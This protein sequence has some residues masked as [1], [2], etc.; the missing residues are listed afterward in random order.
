MG[1]TIPDVKKFLLI[2]STDGKYP[3]YQDSYSQLARLYNFERPAEYTFSLIYLDEDDIPELVCDVNG[4]YM[5]V[6]TFKGDHCQCIMRDYGYGAMG[7]HGYEYAEKKNVVRN[8]NTDYAGLIMN[9]TY[10]Q[11]IDGK[12]IYYGCSEIN[13]A[14]TD[15]DGYPSGDEDQTFLDE[16]YSVSYYGNGGTED[17]IKTMIDKCSV[18]DYKEIRGTMGVVELDQALGLL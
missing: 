12:D 9:I 7:N 8:Y 1:V 15:N 11:F 2:G 5:D 14:D 16:P 18:L 10:T 17:E 4:Y 3:N 13:W 6:Y